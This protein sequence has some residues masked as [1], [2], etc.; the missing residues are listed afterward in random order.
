[1]TIRKAR[2]LLLAMAAGSMSTAVG[3]QVT[4]T[5]GPI[6]VIGTVPAMCYAGTLGNA[7]GVFDL[8]VLI[9]TSTGLLRN[10]L[11]A[12]SKILS[13]AFC[14]TKSTI[15]VSATPLV[16]ENNLEAPSSAFS[17]RV[18][19]VAAAS[20]WTNSP[21]VFATAQGSNPNAVQQRASA[22]QGDIAVGIADFSTAG[23]ASLRLVA[24]PSYRGAVTVTL[25]VAD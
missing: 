12:P 6:P 10:D 25:A 19:Y 23:G 7:D 15:T 2:F 3:A 24:D 11:A 16:A 8:G 17:R 13:G 21:A 22:F 1:M 18:D 20:G 4:D 5:A 9:D 14:S